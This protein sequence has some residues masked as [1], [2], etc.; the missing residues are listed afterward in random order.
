LHCA[1]IDLRGVGAP[2]IFRAELAADLRE[3][4][5]A[6]GLKLPEG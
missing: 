6:R 4:C 5:V 2:E 3:F 1:S